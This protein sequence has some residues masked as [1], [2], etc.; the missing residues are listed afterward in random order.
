MILEK[1][2][3]KKQIMELQKMI[4][5][6]REI[7]VLEINFFHRKNSKELSEEYEQISGVD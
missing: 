7:P 6:R 2:R 4:E 3:N 5:N 1:S